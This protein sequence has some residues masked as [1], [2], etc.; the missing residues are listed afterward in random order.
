MVVWQGWSEPKKKEGVGQ[1]EGRGGGI[2]VCVRGGG[3]VEQGKRSSK[4]WDW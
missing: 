1:R 2:C 3:G 4:L